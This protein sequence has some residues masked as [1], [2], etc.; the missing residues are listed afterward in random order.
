M[1]ETK[2]CTRCQTTK[3]LS[4]F[5][6][7][8]DYRLKAGGAYKAQCKACANARAKAWQQDNYDRAYENQKRWRVENYAQGRKRNDLANK[9]RLATIKAQT[10][11]WADLAKIEEIYTT[12]R[13]L[14][15][16]GHDAEVD[17]IVALQGV[18]ARGLHV[19][20]NLQI[21]TR[22]QNLQKRNRSNPN[23]YDIPNA[24]DTFCSIA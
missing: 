8:K 23:A 9:R 20:W 22:K 4:D 21:V 24:W 15:E 13:L 19:H 2:Q 17:H 6:W 16:A 12:A 10:P 14:R 11:A 18:D 1:S 5:P 7:G 3:P